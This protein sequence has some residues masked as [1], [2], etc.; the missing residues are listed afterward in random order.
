MV[1]V[2]IFQGNQI[3]GCVVVVETK[4]QDSIHR[5]MIDFGSSL[6]GHESDDFVFPWDEEK[7]DGVFFTHNHG[8]HMG[9]IMEIPSDIPLYMGE[10]SR[11]VMKTMYSYLS[12]IRGEEAKENKKVYDLLSSDAV[13][14]FYEYNPGEFESVEIPGFKIEPYRVC[15]SAYDSYMYLIEAYDDDEGKKV[16]LHTGDYRGHGRVAENMIPAI[17]EKIHADG[18]EVNYL[19]TEGTMMSRMDEKV[20]TEDDMMAEAA[21]YL[22]EHRYAFVVCGST[23]L[24]SIASFYN[25]AQM[26]SETGERYVYTYNRYMA[27]QLKVF[28][29]TAG[30]SDE[31][32]N[33]KHVY[34]MDLYK[35][36]KSKQWTNSMTQKKLME[37]TG[38]LAFIKPEE[39]C[40]KFIQPFIDDY[41]LGRTKEKPVII[42]SMWDGY[43]RDD[44]ANT[45]R[46]PEWISFFKKM[47]GQGVEVKH[48][49]TSGHAVPSFIAKV[50]NEVSPTDAI[51]PI[52]TE[53]ADMFK[54]IDIS[55]DLKAKIRY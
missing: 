1:N 33:F 27:S 21:A 55:N 44:Y 48:L 6:P 20:L 28:S 30:T 42:Y 41:L 14:T 7:I 32:Y 38:F 40:E 24:D 26:A 4:Y 13:H 9:R 45:A 51:I 46:I 50:I 25:A 16:I 31:R 15:H 53:H 5:I 11:R 29:E 52:H 35:D 3:G 43:L 2:R 54:N 49:H 37:I 10:I 8:D 12:K 19:I 17:R 34:T 36:L 23:N 22:K 39:R 18:R 47:E